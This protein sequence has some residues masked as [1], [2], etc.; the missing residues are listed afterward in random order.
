ML[1]TLTLALDERH[2]ERKRQHTCIYLDDRMHHLLQFYSFPHRESHE[3][4]HMR[5]VTQMEGTCCDIIRGP[6]PWTDPMPKIDTSGKS[7]ID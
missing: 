3:D 6:R 1:T 2:V 7:S 4:L 5:T